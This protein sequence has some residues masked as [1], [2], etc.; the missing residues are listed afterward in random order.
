LRENVWVA[1]LSVA[2]A[3]VIALYAW[4]VARTDSLAQMSSSHL[5]ESSRSSPWFCSSISL[6]WRALILS[7]KSSSSS[8]RTS[9]NGEFCLFCLNR[10]P[11]EE[12]LSW[13]KGELAQARRPR[14][15][16]SSQSA[17]VTRS[18][19]RESLA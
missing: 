15:S 8:E 2:L 11:G 16:E 19:R 3:C 9:P 1:F 6:R 7:D 5:G 18:L 4:T 17:T 13:V 14:L 12:P 10:S